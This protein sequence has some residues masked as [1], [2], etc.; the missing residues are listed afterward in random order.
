MRLSREASD[1]EEVP[2][3]SIRSRGVAAALLVAAIGASG[4]SATPRSSESTGPTTTS[5]PRGSG[6]S[7]SSSTTPSP[8]TTI[9]NPWR[10]YWTSVNPGSAIDFLTAQRG[11][12]LDGQIWGPRLDNNLGSGVVDNGSAWP[13]TSIAETTDGGRTWTTILGVSTG[14]WGMDLVA[15]NV[16]FAVGVTSLRRTTDGGAHWQQ[17]SEPAGH[18]LVW[19]DFATS[20]LGYGLTTTGTLVR[21]VDSGSSWSSTGMPTT[22]TAAC[23]ASAQVGYVADRSGEVYATRDGGSSWVDVKRAPSRV[24]QFIGSWSDLSCNG[25]NIWLG[26]QLLCAAACAAASPY[27]VAHSAD[28]G[29]S[30]STIASEWPVASATTAPVAYLATVAA[31]LSDHGVIV[32]LPNENSSPPTKP[33]L[34]VLAGETP[35]SAY[36][37]ATVPALPASSSTILDVSVRGVTFVGLTGWLYFD[38]TAVGSPSKPRAEPLVWKTI[39]GGSSWKLLAAGPLQPP[40]SAE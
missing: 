23:F 33:Q 11:W 30:W 39:D 29:A 25:T 40:P 5:A 36:I 12:R 13:G 38:D 28:G 24:E 20:E 21:T 9:A 8:P 26:Q 31:G 1:V 35:G 2:C 16:G 37:T 10:A 15:R 27:L 17:V 14:I 19:V 6:T 7:T 18:A 32:D 4:C 3:V 34:R 22:G